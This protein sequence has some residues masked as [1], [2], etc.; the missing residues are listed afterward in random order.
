MGIKKA[1][2]AAR[3]MG[4]ERTMADANQNVIDAA[5]EAANSPIDNQAADEYS[6]PL[7][8]AGVFII[9]V[10]SISGMGL[11]YPFGWIKSKGGM[12]EGGSSEWIFGIALELLKGCGLGVIICT[13]LIH[14]IGEAYE[15]FEESG[16]AETY[17]Q[18]PMVFAMIGMFIMA[19]LEFFH[20]RFEARAR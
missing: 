4:T 2:E 8:I 17:E 18:W 14:L 7:Q 6:T 5:M 9:I 12:R 20:H 13:S 11:S 16:M 10:A 15:P 19:I 1:S 3:S